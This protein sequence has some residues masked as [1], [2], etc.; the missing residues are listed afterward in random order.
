MTQPLR[1]REPEPKALIEPPCALLVMCVE[2]GRGVEAPL[3]TDRD[4]LARFLAQHGW[5]M[6]VMAP[7]RQGPETPILLGALCGTCAPTVFPPEV[8]KAAEER[9]QLMLR[10]VPES[11]FGAGKGTR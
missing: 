9:R 7:P 11:I 10:S 2:C 5:F 1:G 3:P 8:M 4:I 6:T